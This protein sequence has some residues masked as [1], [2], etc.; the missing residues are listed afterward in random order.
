MFPE[1][2]SLALYSALG[3]VG[4]V[5]HSFL[6]HFFLLVF[7]FFFC[8]CLFTLFTKGSKRLKLHP[9]EHCKW[10]EMEYLHIVVPIVPPGGVF[11]KKKEALTNNL[12]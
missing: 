1:D 6:L 10:P 11:F 7:F 3:V 8:P 9:Y 12:A 4:L 2:E 5:V